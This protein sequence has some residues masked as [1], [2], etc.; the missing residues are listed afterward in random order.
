MIAFRR[1]PGQQGRV[2]RIALDETKIGVIAVRAIHGSIFGKV[3][4]RR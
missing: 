2:F 3:Y 1:E 4:R